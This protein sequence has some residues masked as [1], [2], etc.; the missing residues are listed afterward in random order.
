LVRFVVQSYLYLDHSGAVSHFPNAEYVEQRRELE[1]A[2]TP[3]WFQKPAHIR[4]GFDRDGDWLFVDGENDD[5]YDLYGDGAL[6]RSHHPG[7]RLRHLDRPESGHLPLVRRVR[8]LALRDQ[9]LG[10]SIQR[11]R[12]E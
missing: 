11:G 9:S 4:P 6:K 3:A 7:V 8:G 10:G 1:Y 5:G 12:P 2:Y